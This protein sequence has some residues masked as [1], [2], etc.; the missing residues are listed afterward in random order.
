[1]STRIPWPT[2]RRAVPMAAVVLPFPGP[3]FTMIKPRRIS[4]I[5]ENPDCN[6]SRVFGNEAGLGR[7]PGTVQGHQSYLVSSLSKS[8]PEVMHAPQLFLSDRHPRSCLLLISLAER[9][10]TDHSQDSA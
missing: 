7:I 1:M 9:I 10:R 4:D 6:R 3:V 8:G 5:N 2:A